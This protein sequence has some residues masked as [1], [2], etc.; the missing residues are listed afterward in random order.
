[1]SSETIKQYFRVDL[2][3][4]VESMLR[5]GVL[6]TYETFIHRGKIP[7]DQVKRST[8][9]ALDLLTQVDLPMNKRK[10]AAVHL[11]GKEPSPDTRL[12]YFSSRHDCL[13]K[14]FVNRETDELETERFDMDELP[15]QK[16]ARSEEQTINS[17]FKIDMMSFSNSA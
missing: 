13:V 17:E 12:M 6:R 16:P 7:P 15:N 5:S 8:I 2:G 9:N 10:K 3:I 1:M 4:S 14:F 11:Q